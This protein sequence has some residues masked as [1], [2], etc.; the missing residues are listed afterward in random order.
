MRD[1]FFL[2]IIGSLSVGLT[3]FLIVSAIGALLIG[4]AVLLRIKPPKFH[5]ILQYAALLGLACGALV[6]G[7]GVGVL[8]ALSEWMATT[9]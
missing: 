6:F 7:G 1:L 4:C 9:G 5:L 3:I 2:F 8:L